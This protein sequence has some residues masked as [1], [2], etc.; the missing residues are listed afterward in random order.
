MI[1]SKKKE[2]PKL[3]NLTPNALRHVRNELF[4]KAGDRHGF[5]AATVLFI[6]MLVISGWIDPERRI[7]DSSKL[8]IMFGLGIGVVHLVWGHNLKKLAEEK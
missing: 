2:S 5:G 3:S 4:Y 7:G 1:F 8:F 6:S